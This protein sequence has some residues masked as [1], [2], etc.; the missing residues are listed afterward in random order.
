M[1]GM[2]GSSRSSGR[3][4][5]HPAFFVSFHKSPHLHSR[6]QYTPRYADPGFKIA[7]L[8]TTRHR[9]VG[10]PTL[11]RLLAM[12]PR[13][14]DDKSSSGQSGRCSKA[15]N[16]GHAKLSERHP[17]QR[18]P[19]CPVFRFMSRRLGHQQRSPSSQAPGRFDHRQVGPG[20]SQVVN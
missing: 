8:S 9:R 3:Y 14:G 20:S 4:P 16:D 1:L 10:L 7:L 2:Y 5:V 12:D 11:E 13:T 6:S 18:L 19:L 15:L 17:Q